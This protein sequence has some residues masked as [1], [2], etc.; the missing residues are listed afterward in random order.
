MS[1]SH[2]DLLIELGV[3]E[4]P[5]AVAPAML[6]ALGDALVAL[7][8]EADLAHGKVTELGTPRR[9]TVHIADVVACQED[10]ELEVL[11]PPA[12]VAFA[13][14]GTPTRA[15]DGFLRAQGAEASALL[16]VVTDK[17]E[18]AALWSVR[19]SAR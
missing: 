5:A 14:D 4:I 10:R 18:Y 7:L 15:A 16:R 8:A 2:V 3:E 13:A 19:R 11:G 12:R 9:L 6:R 17:G 1:A